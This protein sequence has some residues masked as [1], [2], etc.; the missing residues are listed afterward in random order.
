MSGETLQ[1]KNSFSQ[2]VRLGH[3]DSADCVRALD[4]DRTILCALRVDTLT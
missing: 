3:R 4:S 2:T 1:V